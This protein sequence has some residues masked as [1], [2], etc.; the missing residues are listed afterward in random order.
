MQE[1]MISLPL[2]HRPSPICGTQGSSILVSE[3]NTDKSKQTLVLTS[4]SLLQNIGGNKL[5]GSIPS[6]IGEMGQLTDLILGECDFILCVDLL[7]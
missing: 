7:Y 2:Y 6:E 1:G 3:S 5:S 4:F